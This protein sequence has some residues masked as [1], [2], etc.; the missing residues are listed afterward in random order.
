LR[1]ALASLP[2]DVLGVNTDNG[3]EFLN[4]HLAREFP[5]LCPGAARSR[6]RPYVKNDNPHVEQ[7]NGHAV[8]RILGYGRL[9]RAE[10][11][12]TL[13]ELLEAESLFRNLYRATFKLE[14]KRREEG[15]W[16]KSF[17]KTP[18]TPLQR[19]L[20]HP[21]VPPPAK[22]RVRAL[23]GGH[24]PVSLRQRIDAL[25]ARLVRMLAAPPPQPAPS[26]PPSPVRRSDELLTAHSR[27]GRAGGDLAQ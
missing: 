11:Y 4:A 15:R 25:A 19:V 10:V 22:A 26:P 21:S 23:A 17:E 27:P 2:F 13:L 9:G 20:A 24:D 6:S 7:K 16:V 14:G 1:L 18:M 5:A 8:R 3:P 12:D